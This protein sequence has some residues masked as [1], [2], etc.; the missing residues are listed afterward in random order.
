[1][2]LPASILYLVVYFVFGGIFY[3]LLTKPYYTHQVAGGEA[4]NVNLSATVGAWFP[5][6]Q[7]ARGALLSL[8]VIPIVR[9]LRVRRRSAALIV[10]SIIWV[11]GG[12]AQL[13]APNDV[14]P[15]PLRFYHIGEIFTQNFTLGVGIVYLMRSRDS[16]REAVAEERVLTTV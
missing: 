7:I 14:M 1:M 16:V 3:L 2:V 4:L 10:G 6:I 9:M 5:L 8:A 15:G 13:V 12:L 11:V